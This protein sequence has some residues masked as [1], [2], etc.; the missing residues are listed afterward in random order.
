MKPVLQALVLAERIYDD[1]TN[2]KIIAGTFNQ[3]MIGQVPVQQVELPDGTKK[4]MLIGGT[5]PGCPS[6]YMS[7]TDIVDG[8]E[9]TLQLVNVS[10]NCVNFGTAFAIKS[11]DR[12]ATVEIIAPL[13]PIAAWGIEP[14]TFSLDVVCEGEIIGSHRIVVKQV[15]A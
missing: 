4:Q 2:K 10:K 9:I 13:P 8:T 6:A 7:F 15:G 11:N 14:G 12:L 3:L 1:K 5:D